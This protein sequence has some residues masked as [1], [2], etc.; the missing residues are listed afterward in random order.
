MDHSGMFITTDERT[1]HYHTQSTVTYAFTFGVP[2]SVGFEQCVITYT[3]HCSI[4]QNRFTALK[5]L[6]ASSVRCSERQATIN[7]FT[8]P[9]V[10][11]SL[12]CHLVGIM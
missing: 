8:V 11:L 2:H 3:H 12:E 9:L 10:L 4:T 7:P 6:C 5:I 1:C